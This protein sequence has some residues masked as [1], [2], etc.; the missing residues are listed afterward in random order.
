MASGAP[1]AG[2]IPEAGAVIFD[3][4]TSSKTLPATTS[5]SPSATCAL[6]TSAATPKPCSKRAKTTLQLRIPQSSSQ[7]SSSATE[8]GCSF[9]APHPWRWPPA[10]RQPRR[11]SGNR[12]DLYLSVKNT[13]TRLEADLSQLNGPRLQQKP[14]PAQT[15]H[16]PPLGTRIRPRIDLRNMVYWME[17]RISGGLQNSREPPSSRPRP[18]TSPAPRRPAFPALPDS[19]DDLSHADSPGQLRTHPQ[20]SR[21]R[22]ETSDARELVVPSHFKYQDQAL[23]YLRPRCQTPRA[24]YP[25]AAPAA[26]NAS[27]KSPK[28]APS[29]SSQ[30]QPDAR[31]LRALASSAR[32][33]ILLH[34]AALEIPCSNN[35]APHPTPS[36][37][38]PQFLARRRRARR[39]LSCVIIDRL[40]FAVPN[41]R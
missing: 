28:A 37:S 32:L 34:G 31:P 13:L 11:V 33:P 20:A 19:R 10:L 36:S 1:D 40:P 7:A 3:E 30:L 29:A 27:W 41:I 23:L 39:S 17:R 12:G 18:S 25:A 14:R 35:S 26:S 8:R 24:N 9:A 38:A 4:A 22:Y 5:A 21:P 16:Q 2:V 6:K 15:R